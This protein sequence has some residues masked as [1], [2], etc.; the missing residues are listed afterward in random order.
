MIF[1]IRYS[2]WLIS[3]ARGGELAISIAK[4]ASTMSAGWVFFKEAIRSDNCRFGLIW[5]GET[6]GLLSD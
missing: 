1:E 2:R 5:E 6:Q 4:A 3:D